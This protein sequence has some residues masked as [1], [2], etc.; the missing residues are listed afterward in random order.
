MSD[1][2]I[3]GALIQLIVILFSAKAVGIIFEKIGQSKVLGEL[4][5]GLI[6]GPSLIGFIDSRNEIILFLAEIGVIVL[7]FE[8]GI[9]SSLHD[10]IKSGKSAFLVACVGVAMPLML[11]GGYILAFTNHGL[12]YAFFI[13]ATLT[14]TSI[15][16]TV[17]VLGEIKKTQSP[18]GKI[19]LGAAVIDDIIGLILLSI[20]T[21][22]TTVGKIIPFNVLKIVVMVV[23]FFGAVLLAGKLFE[24][25]IIST[26]RSLN[27]GRS[28]IISALIFA[29]AMSYIS[30]SIG[31]A[32]IVG[33][34]AAGIVLER[35]ED[36]QHIREKTH[37]L[38]QVF[39]PI[40]FVVAG[41]AVNIWSLFAI[42]I[43]P[44]IAILTIIAIVG[45]V[46]AGIGVVDEKASKLAVGFG[47]LPRGE[48]GL[49]FANYGLKTALVTQ[50]I[51]SALVAVIMITTFMAP[52]LI[53]RAMRSPKNA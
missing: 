23:L 7:L 19:I 32:T 17:R 50:D 8:A 36:K 46:V 11:A 42:E 22:M 21:D 5:A 28:F 2:L 33:A 53:R 25:S 44:L 26:V 18:E 40:F 29:L 47:M 41:A 27:I 30:L 38:V 10:L 1:A 51:Y 45:K 15:G 52:P 13:G 49:I 12:N 3:A 16:L 48:V 31:L 6:L 35:E 24:K 43:L 37:V 20:L 4:L 39:A 14:A 9:E 34:F